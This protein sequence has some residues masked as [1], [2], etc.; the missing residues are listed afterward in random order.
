MPSSTITSKGQIT[1]PSEVRRSAGLD[2][3]DR[4]SFR[5]REDGVIEMQPETVDLLSLAGVL[6]PG[7]R[8]LTLE[9]FE[10]A[11]GRGALDR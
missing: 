9:D 6:K 4:V 7:V 8:G 1:I 2:T 5:V 10:K 11:I 3:G